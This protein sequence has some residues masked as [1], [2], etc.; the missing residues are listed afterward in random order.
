ML[1]YFDKVLRFKFAFCDKIVLRFSATQLQVDTTIL[2]MWFDVKRQKRSLHAVIRSHVFVVRLGTVIVKKRVINITVTLTNVHGA[3]DS[4]EFRGTSVA[5]CPMITPNSSFYK[6]NVPKNMD[7]DDGRIDYVCSFS[8]DF[9]LSRKKHVRPADN[10]K[11][12]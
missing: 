3:E 4:A 8:F 1:S 2:K 10:D 5:K 7:T 9:S 12:L 6:P 11:S